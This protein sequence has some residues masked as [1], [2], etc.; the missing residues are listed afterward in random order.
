MQEN[1]KI[2]L[3]PRF[4]QGPEIVRNPGAKQAAAAAM[5]YLISQEE[6]DKLRALGLLRHPNIYAAVC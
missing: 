5:I 3:D 1:G 4:N 2:K 6:A